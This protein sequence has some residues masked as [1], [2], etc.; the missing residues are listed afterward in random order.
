MFHGAANLI[1]FGGLTLIMAPSMALRSPHFW[2]RDKL[3][4]SGGEKSPL[5]NLLT[6]K[7]GPFNK[8]CSPIFS[9]QGVITYNCFGSFRMVVFEPDFFLG[10]R[11]HGLNLAIKPTT[12]LQQI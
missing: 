12:L 6:Y 10:I 5:K 9:P 2:L 3:T 8:L 4:S 11:S 7:E 1:T